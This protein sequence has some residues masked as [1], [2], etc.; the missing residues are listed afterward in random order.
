VS[1]TTAVSGVKQAWLPLCSMILAAC[2]AAPAA[3]PTPPTPSTPPSGPA[4]VAPTLT[5]TPAGT[6]AVTAAPTPAGAPV[7]QWTRTGSLHVGRGS[8]AATILRSGDVLVTGGID[9][10][11]DRTWKALD[12][13]EIYSPKTGRWRTVAPMHHPRFG[14]TATLLHD[15]RVLVVGGTCVGMLQPNC[16][17][18]IDPSGAQSSAEIYDPR[19][20]TWADTA[21]MARERSLQTATL[22]ADGRVLVLGAELAPDDVLGSSETWD[23]KTGE[24]TSSALVTPRWQHFAIA[25]PDG[26]ALIAGGYGPI[27]LSDRLLRST[28]IYSSKTD[29][30]R[31]GP[32]MLEGR[33]QGGTAALLGDGRI[34]VAGGDGGG[35]RMRASAEIYDPIVGRWSQAAAMAGPRAESA[36][37]VLADGRVLVAGGFSIPG[38]PLGIITSSEV[39]DPERDAWSNGGDIAE[40]RLDLTATRLLDGTVLI[41]GGQTDTGVS[42]IAELWRPVGG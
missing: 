18:P 4:S 5:V 36:F 30:W 15:G 35:D 19:T 3:T 42:T 10:N 14:H 9:S 12:S 22:L 13:A 2:V 28:E 29:T 1:A 27:S 16:S 11:D 6:P 33:A 24:W 23:P 37:V 26:D 38:N 20:G 8:F 21:S 32:D 7:G 39:Y 40:F 31:A 17:S 41:V 25:L 34:L